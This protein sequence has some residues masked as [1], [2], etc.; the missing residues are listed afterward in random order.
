[1]LQHIIKI[2]VSVEHVLLF[3]PRSF[4]TF[5]LN[6]EQVLIIIMEALQLYMFLAGNLS[7]L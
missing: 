6:I 2:P 3:K 1:M 5:S 4:K 7:T